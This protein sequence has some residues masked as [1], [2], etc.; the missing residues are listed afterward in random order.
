MGRGTVAG[1]DST[2]P[3]AIVQVSPL[4]YFSFFLPLPFPHLPR[5][6]SLAVAQPPIPFVSSEIKYT[7]APR[8]QHQS[9]V[10]ISSD[11][12]THLLVE[13]KLRWKQFHAGASTLHQLEIRRRD[14]TLIYVYNRESG[15]RNRYEATHNRY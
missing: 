2:R 6:G 12:H 11:N 14:A 1:A 5:H 3:K 9:F 4:S 8:A 15:S 13:E 10:Y 7:G